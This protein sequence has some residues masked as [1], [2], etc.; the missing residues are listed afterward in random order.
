MPAII[1]KIKRLFHPHSEVFDHD[2]VFVIF[3]LGGPGA[4]K[5]TQCAKLVQEFGFSHLSAGD[6]LRAEQN[7]EGSQYGELIRQNIREG[8]IVPSEVT[9]GLLRNAIAAELEKRKE[10]TEQGWGDGKGRFL[11]D[12]FPRQMDQAHIFD[13]QVCESKFVLF[14]VTSEEVLLQRLL[15]RGKTSG[16]EDDNEESI[17]K[18]FK[19]FVETSMPVVEYY[20]KHDKVIE[21]DATKSIDDVYTHTSAAVRERLSI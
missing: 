6:L 8:K 19:T 2:K 17:K 13:E 1:D 20:K 14:F 11:V 21:I 16:R 4:G 7:R 18:R 12:G 3:V 10:N 15:E 5:G 9:V